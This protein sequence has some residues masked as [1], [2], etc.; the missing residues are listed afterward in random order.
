MVGGESLVH[1]NLYVPLHPYVWGENYLP[2][3]YVCR[4]ITQ[5][6]IPIEEDR[7]RL[8]WSDGVIQNDTDS[9]ISK[10]KIYRYARKRHVYIRQFTPIYGYLRL[11][12]P[13]YAN[14]NLFLSFFANNLTPSPQKNCLQ[15]IFIGEQY[16][17]R[18]IFSQYL[19]LWLQIHNL[20]DIR[21]TTSP[22]Q[23]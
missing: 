11:F 5:K 4:T 22:K 12:T 2:H 6:N 17:R 13:N 18:N 3:V 8:P 20:S 19:E 9:A 10:V 21:S 14:N 1:G 15:D 23:L 16:P 7:R